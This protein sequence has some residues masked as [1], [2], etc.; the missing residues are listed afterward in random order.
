MF[1]NDS[2]ILNKI[3]PTYIYQGSVPCVKVYL[4]LFGDNSIFGK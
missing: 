4:G 1:Y 3:V 2:L